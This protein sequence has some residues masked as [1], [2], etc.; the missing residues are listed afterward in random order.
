MWLS[1]KQLAQVVVSLAFNENTDHLA[2]GRNTLHLDETVP[3][4]TFLRSDGS[5]V[6]LSAF[7]AKPLVLIFLRHLG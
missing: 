4:F 2:R 1:S 7:S 3:D 5:S 6:A